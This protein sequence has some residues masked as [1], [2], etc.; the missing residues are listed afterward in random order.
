MT[1]NKKIYEF[2]KILLQKDLSREE[3]IKELNISLKAFYKYFE[4]AKK[5]DF[6]I[7]KHDNK[8][9]ILTFKN[10]LSLNENQINT[11]AYLFA[12]SASTM[13][14]ENFLVV[15]NAL[16]YL[17]MESSEQNYEEVH[18]KFKL[19]SEKFLTEKYGEKINLIKKYINLNEKI[20]I[21]ISKNEL[22]ISP[23]ELLWKQNNAY[24]VYLNLNTGVQEKTELDKTHKISPLKILIIEKNKKDT[25]FELYG[26]LAKRYLLKDEEYIIESSQ[27]KLVVGNTTGNKEKLFKRL[28]RYDT[29]CKVVFPKNDVDKMLD[30]IKK[31]LDN[32]D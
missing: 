14:Y 17:L 25:I 6:K 1:T 28:M 31:S 29:L 4:E 10:E 24:L 22:N 16:N 9:K 26:S 7:I 2:I 3:L 32:L 18:L 19:Y 5:A 12:I 8:F 15:K 13:P 27:D 21:T 11:L 20:T 23:K 30:T